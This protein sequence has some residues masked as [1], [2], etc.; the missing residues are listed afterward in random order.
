MVARNLRELKIK[1]N[2]MSDQVVK[3]DVF[4]SNLHHI[5]S[6]ELLYV[7]VDITTISEFIGK[8]KKLK[9]LLIY[10]AVYSPSD[11]EPSQIEES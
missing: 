3:T 6:L 8:L 4:I 2:G 9:K 11:K 10:E 7:R 1:Y 5:E